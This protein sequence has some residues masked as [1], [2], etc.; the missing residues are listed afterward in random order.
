MIWLSK[1]ESCLDV[2]IYHLRIAGWLWS[3][4]E[5]CLAIPWPRGENARRSNMAVDKLKWLFA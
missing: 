2:A 3:G 4:A 1:V 5:R